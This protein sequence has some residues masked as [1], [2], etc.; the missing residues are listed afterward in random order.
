MLTQYFVN[1]NFL[2]P[3]QLYKFRNVMY[4]GVTEVYELLIVEMNELSW[5]LYL[6]QLL[7]CYDILIVCKSIKALRQVKNKVL[8]TS[9]L[10]R[11]RPYT[12]LNYISMLSK[13]QLL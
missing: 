2:F 5:F 1:S 7:T 10:L 8:H 3:T 6:E 13:S 4:S 9:C 11:C 12:K